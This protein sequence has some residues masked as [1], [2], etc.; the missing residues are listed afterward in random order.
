[1]SDEVGHYKPSPQ[2]FEAALS[3]LEATPGAAMHVGD[4]RRTDIAGA[5]AL[6][7]RTV[8]Y[9]ALHDDPG[10]DGEV[11]ADVL[12]DDHRDLPGIVDRGGGRPPKQPGRK[13][14]TP[15]A[16]WRKRRRS[17]WRA[18]SPRPSRTRCSGSNSTTDTTCSVTSRARCAATTSASSPATG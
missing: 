1:F 16:A 6:G 17:R 10:L 5:A 15:P 18:K 13:Q 14:D 8:R 7:M 3:S 11:E 9:R 12:L 2:I 4:L